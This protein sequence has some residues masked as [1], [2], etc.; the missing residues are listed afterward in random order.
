MAYANVDNLKFH[1]ERYDGAASG[2]KTPVLFLHGFTLDI[3]QWAPQVAALGDRLPMILMDARGHGQSDAPETGY[4]RDDRVTD[5]VGFMDA[6]EIEKVHLVGLSM[7]GTTALGTA[8]KHPERL[9]SL[10]LVSTGAAGYSVGKKIEYIDRI[11]REKGLEA[12]RRKWKETSLVYYKDDRTKLREMMLGMVDDHSGAIWMDPMRGKYP[13][14]VDLDRVHEIMTPTAIFVGE[15]DRVF[16]ALA[17]E[18]H[19]RIVCSR[20]VVYENTG[21]MI[22]LEIPDRFNRDLERFLTGVESSF[23]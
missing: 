9:A 8:L 20:I 2:V 16:L 4:G 22:N 23:E 10:T 17:Q 5:V 3:R 7:G 21:H 6:L 11:A 19:E 18:L 13:R 14:T 15:K 1:Y 12:A